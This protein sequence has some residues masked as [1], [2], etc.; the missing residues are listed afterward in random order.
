MDIFEKRSVNDP[1]ATYS[2]PNETVWNWKLALATLVFFSIGV[3][4]LVLLPARLL[5]ELAGSTVMTAL[6]TQTSTWMIIAS[7]FGLTVAGI[8]SIWLVMIVWRKRTWR[9]LGFRPLTSR[10]IRISLWLSIGLMIL[11]VIIG[12]LIAVNFPSLAEGLEEMLFS[13]DNGLLT[14]IAIIILTAIIVPIWEELF[15]R[16]FLYKWSR[17]RL[18]IWMGISLNAVLFGLVHVIP[19]QV[20]LAA[21]MGFA[22]AW[23]YE[24]SNSLW[25]PILM[26]MFNNLVVGISTIWLIYMENGMM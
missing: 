22:L 12:T 6:D 17:N 25:A 1:S 5:P 2:T 7:T 11:R 15:F 23:V 9:E 16:G 18:G 26:H 10:W 24:R 13:P 21:V 19:L 20:F 3:G 14:T 8:G 4:L